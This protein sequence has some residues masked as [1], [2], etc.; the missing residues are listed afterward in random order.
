MGTGYVFKKNIPLL[1]FVWCFPSDNVGTEVIDLRRTTDEKCH[2]HRITSNVHTL[3]TWLITDL[4]LLMLT[5][6]TWLNW[7]LSGFS[8]LKLL[9]LPLSVLY[10]LEECHYAQPTLKSKYVF[11]NSL[12]SEYFSKLFRIILHGRL[13]YSYLF[14]YPPFIYPLLLYFVVQIIADITFWTIYLYLE[15]LRKIVDS[16]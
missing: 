3:C 12:K 8:T 1:G 9:F 2:S 11:S 6:I 5:F 13:S 10:S 4:L 7:S 15:V 16:Q 14:I